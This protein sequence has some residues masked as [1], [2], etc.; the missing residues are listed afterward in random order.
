MTLSNDG[1]IQ[2]KGTLYCPECHGKGFIEFEHGLIQKACPNCKGYS[3]V[4]PQAENKE[5]GIPDTQEPG[6]R[7]TIQCD[8]EEVARIITDG[9]S[10]SLTGEP[11]PGN[12]EDSNADDE[13]NRGDNRHTGGQDTGQSAKPRKPKAKRKAKSRPV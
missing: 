2:T 13:G 6:Y 11:I 3:A 1:I 10:T 7:V 9:V 4:E 5:N 12:S 8:P